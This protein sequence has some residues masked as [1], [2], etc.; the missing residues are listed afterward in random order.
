M[1]WR[2]Y[3]LFYDTGRENSNISSK[4]LSPKFGKYIINFLQGFPYH[5]LTLYH[6]KN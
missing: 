6:K 3:G 4:S 2:I 5:Y 1:F